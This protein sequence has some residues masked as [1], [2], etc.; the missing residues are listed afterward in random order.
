MDEKNKILAQYQES[1][2]WVG[3]LESLSEQQWRQ[4]I[5]PNKWTIA[6]IIGHL[7]PWDHFITNS[8]MPYFFSEQP[9]PKGP[10]A[11]L[12]N[13]QA[14]EDSIKRSKAET[15]DLFLSTR[16]KLIDGINQISDELWEQEF[17]IGQTKLTLFKYLSGMIEHDQ[18][19]FEQIRQ[20]LNSP[21]ST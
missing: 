15:I 20:A 19:H 5:A 17:A 2:T 1:V 21:I 4:R 7:I 10:D 11:E 16:K 18:H 14:S 13:S 3:S 8:R 6:E 9:L 12:I